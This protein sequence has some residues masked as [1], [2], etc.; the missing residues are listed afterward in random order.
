MYYFY[1]RSKIPVFRKNVSQKFI[2][3]LKF[4]HHLL[5]VMRRDEKLSIHRNNL[6]EVFCTIYLSKL[7]AV[8]QK[9]IITLII[10]NKPATLLKRDPDTGVLQKVQKQPPEVFWKKKRLW[11]RCLPVNFA[12]FPRTPFFQNTF[13]RLLLKVLLNFQEDLFWN[14]YQYPERLF[15]QKRFL[16]TRKIR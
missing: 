15:L 11:H 1:K 16:L 3:L 13:G 10:I 12:K 6:S 7:E 9:F 8:S 5:L 14:T 2:L 4:I